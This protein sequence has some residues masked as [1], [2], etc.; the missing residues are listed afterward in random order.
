MIALLFNDMSPETNKGL[1]AAG[2]AFLRVA[3]GLMIFYIHGLR[4]LEGGIEYFRSGT[5][6]VLENEVAGMHSAKKQA[7]QKE[8]MP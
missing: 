6:W 1:V 8:E 4:K 2:H 3:A 5:P 7:T